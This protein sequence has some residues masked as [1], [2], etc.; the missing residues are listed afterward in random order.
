M[1]D[2]EA[3]WRDVLEA[4]TVQDLIIGVAAAASPVSIRRTADWFKEAVK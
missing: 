1:W 2:A 4:T 3:A